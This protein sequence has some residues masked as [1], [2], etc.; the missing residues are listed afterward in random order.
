M[1]DENFIR[2]AIAEKVAQKE[3]CDNDAQ[4][5]VQLE[6]ELSYW[7]RMLECQSIYKN[8]KKGAQKE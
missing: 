7:Q 8:D 2:Y 6:R 1:I 5:R 3:L 4:R